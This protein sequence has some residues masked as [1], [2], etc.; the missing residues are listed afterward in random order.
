MC[1]LALSLGHFGFGGGGGGGSRGPKK[2][3]CPRTLILNGTLR[4]LQ[5]HSFT[6]PWGSRARPEQ[7]E[8]DARE[9]RRRE[10]RKFGAFYASFTQKWLLHHCTW[11]KLYK[12]RSTLRMI[13]SHCSRTRAFCVRL[14]NKMKRCSRA[15]KAR[16]EKIGSILCEFYAKAP[17]APLCLAQSAQNTQ[18][19]ENAP[20]SLT[21]EHV[22][23]A[24]ASRTKR[25]R[26]LRAPKARA[27]KFG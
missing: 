11:Q 17:F 8:K 22:G 21:C 9:R 15:L 6:N 23:F 13:Q 1:P 4:M 3:E 10:R 5:S 20:K 26:C 18:C 24:R 25:K 19:F 7:S 2:S 14:H 16:A 12:T 27:E